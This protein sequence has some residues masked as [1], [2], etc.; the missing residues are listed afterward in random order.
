MKINRLKNNEQHQVRIEKLKLLQEKK[1][2]SDFN[3]GVPSH[4]AKD[5]HENYSHFSK[6]ELENF[7]QEVS[8][9]G[10]ILMIRNFGQ[11][12]FLS[13][14]DRSSIIQLYLSKNIIGV[15]KFSLYQYLDIGDFI[16]AQGKLFKTKTNELTIEIYEFEL[17]TK[18]LRP[19]PEKFH[20]ISDI[21]IKYRQR[22]LDL[23]LNEEAREVFFK[24]SQIIRELRQFFI[25]RDFIEVE[26]PMMHPIAG[27][28]SARPFL[29]DH[30]AL[31]MNLFLRIAPELYLKRLI[32]GGLERVFEINRNFRNEGLSIQ[33]NPEFTMLEFYQAYANFE[34]LMKIIESLFQRIS[35]AIF[36]KNQFIYQD[37]ELNLCSP[38]KRIRLEDAILTY[39]DFK[40]PLKLRNQDALLQYC[41]MKKIPLTGETSTGEL[42]IHIFEQEVE[43]KLIQPTFVTHY[44]IEV[45]PLS[46]KNQEDPFL[47]DRFEVY[48]YGREIANAFS[49]LND[50]FEQRERFKAQILNQS[51]EIEKNYK[52]EL[53]EDYLLALE[54]GMP[55]TAG[56]GIGVDRLVMLFT[57][58][59]S[60]RD[61][62]L[63]P[64]MRPIQS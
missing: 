25:E 31:K 8:I 43:S 59:S 49:E 11:A 61:V 7:N 55:P 26:T 46:K 57:N 56:A 44:P 41:Q 40:D 34:D 35:Q 58:A 54:Y 47:A 28:A 13:V 24:R 21:E 38:W 63:F 60:I 51:H 12:G 64:L 27:G 23:I 22:Y 19:L 62:I 50:P 15:E 6:D 18:C 37:I 33:H 16:F 3:Q 42:L 29:T 2:L 53:D 5:L 10:R 48:V 1:L 14:Q 9:S 30:H 52:N 32:V 45:S 4:L 17:L 39:S 36:K 20:K